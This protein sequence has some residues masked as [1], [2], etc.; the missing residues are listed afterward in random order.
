M[1]NPLVTIIIPVYN[2]EDY[3]E[4]CVESVLNQ[5]YKNI[6][7]I[8][9]DDGATDSSG[10]VCEELKNRDN[11]IKV[12][13]KANG[14]LADARNAA[15]DVMTG[16]Y[17]TCI[18]SDDWVSEDYISYLLNLLLDNDCDISM[19]QLK[20]I[21]KDTDE[22]DQI[23]EKVEIIGRVE[24]I[25][26]Y[27]YQKKF[28]ASAHCK[29]Y[30]SSVLQGI[31]YPKGMYYEDMAVICQLLDMSDK[32]TVSNQQKYYYF[33]RETSIMGESFNESK[34]HRIKIAEEIY[35]FIA[36]KYPD[37]TDAAKFRI[38]LAAVQTYREIPYRDEYA[39]YID[40][41][42]TNIKKY[43]GSVIRNK[44]A[45]V[46]SRFIAISSVLGKR[47]FNWL[48]DLYTKVCKNIFI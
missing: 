22:L 18:D 24:A 40:V 42:W 14:G 17:V 30:K 28:T 2:V 8:L 10:M 33:Q 38:F 29:M 36:E 27:L 47:I 48:G 41:A 37:L 34:M 15:I 45:K 31:R 7:I 1:C 25:E 21:Y 13:H 3:L 4:K 12:I 19:V 11:R 46:S 39:D 44:K 32:V 26:C 16:E 23:E 5:T 6:E 9:V 43:R 20:K 35:V